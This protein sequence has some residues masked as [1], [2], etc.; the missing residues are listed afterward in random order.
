MPITATRA[1]LLSGLLVLAPAVAVATHGGAGLPAVVESERLE[2]G[3]DASASGPCR[4]AGVVQNPSMSETVTVR[5][6]WRGVGASGTT[7]AMASA[8]IPWLR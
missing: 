6:A 7:V 3:L 5:L 2:A 1:V 8:R 4:V